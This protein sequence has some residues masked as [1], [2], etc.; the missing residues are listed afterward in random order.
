MTLQAWKPKAWWDTE[1]GAKV[2]Q[3]FEAYGAVVKERETTGDPSAVPSPDSVVVGGS[4]SA[5]SNVADI[6]IAYTE[7]KR[8][9]DRNATRRQAALIAFIYVDGVD[10][11]TRIQYVFTD[12]SESEW[13]NADAHEAPL[14]PV[15]EVNT[16]SERIY[17]YD[18]AKFEAPELDEFGRMWRTTKHGLLKREHERT[19]RT[20]AAFA[21]I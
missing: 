3:Y 19:A 15:K 4:R 16:K 13:M 5:P 12:G 20:F 21:G 8:F 14:V 11:D 17:R 2:R 1:K 18:L 10:Y 6:L 9:L 7:V